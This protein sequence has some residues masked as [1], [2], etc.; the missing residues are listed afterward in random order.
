NAI[1]RVRC[2]DRTGIIAALS[3]FVFRHGGNI[4]DLDQH[5]E[6]ETGRFFMRLVWSVDAFNLDRDGI[7]LGLEGFARSLGLHWEVDFDDRRDRV[8]IFCSKEPH[9]LYDLLLRQRL[10]ELAGDVVLV[11]SNHPDARPAAEY[12][13]LPFEVVPISREDK[14]AGETRQEELLRQ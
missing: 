14:V 1:L 4:F 7:R 10:G 8:A 6:P 11:V 5:T 13:G 9:C 12:F 3:D 2:Q